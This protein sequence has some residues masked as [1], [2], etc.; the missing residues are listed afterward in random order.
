MGLEQ[1]HF[2]RSPLGKS[3]LC[4]SFYSDMVSLEIHLWRVWIWS[5]TLQ[6]DQ[7]DTSLSV[8][9]FGGFFSSQREVRASRADPSRQ[10]NVGASVAPGADPIACAGNSLASRSP[11]FRLSRRIR[12]LTSSIRQL[13]IASEKTMFGGHSKI[14]GEW[15]YKGCKFAE[16]APSQVKSLDEEARSIGGQ[17]T[18]YSTLSGKSCVDNTR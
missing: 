10:I 9:D 6:F 1:R 15:Q 16:G 11:L 17:R 14:I 12:A 3:F 8:A 18:R 4:F 7:G 2:I 13:P 5:P